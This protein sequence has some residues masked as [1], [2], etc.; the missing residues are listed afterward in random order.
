MGPTKQKCSC[1]GLCP[2]RLAP[3]ART[4]IS[5]SYGPV[6]L[7]GEAAPAQPRV[8]QLPSVT[9]VFIRNRRSFWTDIQN[10]GIG[11][12]GWARVTWCLP[13]ST[14]QAL[15]VTTVSTRFDQVSAAKQV[16]LLTASFSQ[17][18][19]FQLAFSPSL[20]FL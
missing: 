2:A 19:P 11:K 15:L 3:T 16:C 20:R 10:P 14:A 6:L 18:P 13:P 7:W 4:G 12:S 17:A 5:I 1:S 9:A 8:L